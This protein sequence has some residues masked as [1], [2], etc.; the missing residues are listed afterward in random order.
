MELLNMRSNLE[1]LRD[2]QKLRDLVGLIFQLAII[3]CGITL[4]P[5]WIKAWSPNVKLGFFGWVALIF[6]QAAWPLGVFFA[7]QALFMRASEIR[8]LRSSRHIVAPMIEQF[9]CGVGEAVLTITVVMAVPALVAVWF[10]G[11][12]LTNHLKP[13]LP[14]LSN[15][16]SSK[17][18]RPASAAWMFDEG[19]DAA[20]D[21]MSGFLPQSLAQQ[22]R[23]IPGLQEE[24]DEGEE[25]PDKVTKK[26]KAPKKAKGP[27]ARFWPG[28]YT[29]LVLPL[30]GLVKLLIMYFAAELISVAFKIS[31]DV[32]AL[33]QQKSAE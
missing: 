12:D 8:R 33:R 32:D 1:K 30:M 5:T 7:L 10:N 17:V 23:N 6:W 15:A 19:T 14:L 31:D 28:I 29:L 13:T 21:Q 25:A 2:G 26:A 11:S 18:D 4:I 9:L 27:P 16:I 20:L 24:Q 3:I 22:L